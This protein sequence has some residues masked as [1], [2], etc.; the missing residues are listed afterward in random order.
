M[1]WLINELIDEDTDFDAYKT[2]SISIA[3]ERD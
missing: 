2:I 1:H 3:T